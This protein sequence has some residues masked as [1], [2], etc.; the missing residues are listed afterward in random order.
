MW[1]EG[2]SKV[3]MKINDYYVDLLV[4]FH[5]IFDKWLIFTTKEQLICLYNS[6]SSINEILIF[7]FYHNTW[8]N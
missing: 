3:N 1:I 7:L 2:S 6:T 4:I 8:C 5:S